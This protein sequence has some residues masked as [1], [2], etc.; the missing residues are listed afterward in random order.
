MGKGKFWL[1]LR[2]QLR[3]WIEPVGIPRSYRLV[4]SIPLNTQG[5]RLV[6]DLEQLFKADNA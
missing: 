1:L 4:E 5:K 6:S 2:Q 3:Q